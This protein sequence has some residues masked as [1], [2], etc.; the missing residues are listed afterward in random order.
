MQSVAQL[1]LLHDEY[2]HFPGAASRV[3]V[4][5]LSGYTYDLELEFDH[6]SGHRSAEAHSAAHDEE[7]A[8]T[9]Q[10]GDDYGDITLDAAR[11]S[12]ATAAPTRRR[13]KAPQLI[14]E[15][16]DVEIEAEEEA[17]ADDPAA[18][19][20]GCELEETSSAASPAAAAAAAELDP[21]AD[22]EARI[23]M[24]NHHQR[25]ATFESMA[26][27]LFA[28]HLLTH[29][30]LCTSIATNA[31]RLWILLQSGKVVA[32]ASAVTS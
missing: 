15:E 26:R 1:A 17:I 3:Q 27:N 19:S 13:K 7:A 29:S 32:K 10:L 18:A 30:T 12:D 8:E 21:Q 9:T 5:P 14:V 4:C 22:V 2:L 24:G 11:Q 20:A 16:A 28:R 31:E 25:L 23:D 6:F